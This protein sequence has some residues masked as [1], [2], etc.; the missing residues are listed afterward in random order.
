[1]KK[2]SVSAAFLL[3]AL[4]L[5][6]ACAAAS[7]EEGAKTVDARWVKAMKANDLEGVVGCYA[8]DAVL[9]MPDAPEARGTKAI[10][11]TYAGLMGA[12]TVVDAAL[13]NTVY[14]TSGDLS[15]A[16]GNFVLTLH[17]KAGGEPVVMKGR[18]TSVS[19]P[20]G[21]KWVYLADQASTDP[22]PPAPAAAK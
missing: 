20:V 9:W 21:G 5:P 17:P 2:I 19:K 6:L 1:M 7:A 18:F 4:A 3:A 16:W 13:S 12:N 11:E 8:P 22:P 15:T 10:R 14:Q